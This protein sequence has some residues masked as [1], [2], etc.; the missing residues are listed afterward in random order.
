MKSFK[1]TIEKIEEVSN[2]GEGIVL[3]WRY[4]TGWPVHRDD[5]EAFCVHMDEWFEVAGKSFT[6]LEYECLCNRYG[7]KIT[8]DDDIGGYGC[9]Y[10]DFGMSHYHTDPGNRRAGM[11]ATIM[12]GRWYG[13]K[14]EI[15]DIVEIR[16]RK[17]QEDFLIKCREDNRKTWPVDFDAYLLKL[18]GLEKIYEEC[19]K[20][21][22]NNSI[23]LREKGFHFEWLIGHTCMHLSIKASKFE[24]GYVKGC[25]V[26]PSVFPLF[27]DWWGD[28][29]NSEELFTEDHP[30]RRIAALLSDR[31]IEPYKGK[32]T[33]VGYGEDCGDDVRK[34]LKEWLL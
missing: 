28:W 8:S 27:A 5:V 22:S 2:R 4:G 13:I 24:P 21:H 6:R 14:K 29:S 33:Y 20:L 19:V 31:R 11:E 7:L 12:Q 25:G 32:V 9:V 1:S 26:E 15:P 3:I 34:N 16:L 30:I 10:G 17:K 18:G 23:Q